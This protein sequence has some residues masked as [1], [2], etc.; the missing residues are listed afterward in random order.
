MY[1]PAPYVDAFTSLA[2]LDPAEA[3]R[4]T[5][6]LQAAQ[7]TIQIDDLTDSVYR[8]LGDP[9]SRDDLLAVLGATTSLSS[10]RRANGW[11]AAEVGARIASAPNLELTEQERETLQGRV[12]E[13]VSVASVA[14]LGKAVDLATEH[15]KV[16]IA[17]QSVTDLRPL[18][19][20]DPELRPSAALLS[21]TLKLEYI[22][23]DGRVGNIY[24]V[25]D[26]EDVLT[27][28]EDLD[29]ALAKSRSMRSILEDSGMLYLGPTSENRI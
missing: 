18:F 10:V 15:D 7:P 3:D 20:D 11:T 16:Y 21:H 14:L 24:V 17:S 26:D 23:D 19:G 8:D 12:E 2:R 1:V 5:A 13:V 25:L 22:H 9:W 27:L 4:L 6:A 29:R 28:R